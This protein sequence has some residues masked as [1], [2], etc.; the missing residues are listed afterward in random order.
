MERIEQTAT[1][2][3]W[4]GGNGGSWYFVTFDGEVAEALSATRLMR[5]LESGRATGFGSIRV[6]ARIGGSGWETSVFPQKDG[7]WIL[8]VKAPVR[9]AEGLAEGQEVHC[10]LEF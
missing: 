6:R 10:R 9:R 3:R 2:W 1:L 8:P 4:T 7:S 5:R